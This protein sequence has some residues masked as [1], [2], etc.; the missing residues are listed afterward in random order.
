MEKLED[1]MYKKEPGK[2][3]R[4]VATWAANGD[5][6]R[7]QKR[8]PNAI[9][10][11]ELMHPDVWSL[12]S[13]ATVTNFWALIEAI[14]P[15]EVSM[16]NACRD[17]NGQGVVD[18]FSSEPEKLVV[19]SSVG[20]DLSRPASTELWGCL[21]D[22]AVSQVARGRMAGILGLA[23][24]GVSAPGPLDAKL[25]AAIGV[26]IGARRSGQYIP[27]TTLHLMAMAQRWEVL[28]PN[29]TRKALAWLSTGVDKSMR[30]SQGKDALS[31]AIDEGNA[32][33]AKLLL[34]LGLDPTR[35]DAKGR[36]AIETLDRRVKAMRMHNDFEKAKELEGLRLYLMGA[37]ERRVLDSVAPWASQ[38]PARRR[39]SL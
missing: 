6:T 35:K 37:L 29:D 25:G 34:E 8:V 13:K 19:L 16:L 26:R 9:G 10:E 38:E 2:N 1:T 30:D 7:A 22:P 12:W 31:L 32:G 36:D 17:R 3:A 15:V 11:H 5:M 33:I 18:F 39:Q 28:D 23:S 27:R 21:V 14:H 4:C 24:A 20:I